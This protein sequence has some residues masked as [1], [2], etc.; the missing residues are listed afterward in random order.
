MLVTHHIH[1]VEKQEIIQCV[2]R[3]VSPS[4]AI[5][6][7]KASEFGVQGFTSEDLAIG[8]L[9]REPRAKAGFD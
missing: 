2:F 6:G 1:F 5:E 9:V 7:T 8:D 3:R 4:L